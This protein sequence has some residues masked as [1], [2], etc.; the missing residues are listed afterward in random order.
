MIKTDMDSPLTRTALALLIVCSVTA[1]LLMRGAAL[2]GPTPT[3]TPLPS[4]ASAR[5]GGFFPPLP[6]VPDGGGTLPGITVSLP[7]DNFDTSVPLSAVIIEPVTTTLIDSTTTGGANLVGFQGDFTFDS[8]IV[9][10]ATP[11]LQSA[12]LTSDAN[13]NRSLGI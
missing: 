13:W 2:A 12:G 4:P 11:G 5:Q 9:G 7:F 3:P 6:V 1:S 10:F 8:A